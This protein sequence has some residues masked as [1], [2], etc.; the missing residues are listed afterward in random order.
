MV[1]MLRIFEFQS[2][3]CMKGEPHIGVE[4]DDTGEINISEY[5]SQFSGSWIVRKKLGKAHWS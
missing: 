5:F 2:E 4:L 3:K 1:F